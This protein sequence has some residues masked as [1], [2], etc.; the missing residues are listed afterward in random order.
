[1]KR[2]ATGMLAIAAGIFVA[3]SALESMAKKARTYLERV[4]DEHNGTPWAVSATRELQTPL[5]WMWEEQ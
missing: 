3:A 5:G 2:L 1:M 4:A